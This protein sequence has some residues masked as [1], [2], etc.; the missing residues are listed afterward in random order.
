MEALENPVEWES[1]KE[2]LKSTAEEVIRQHRK[3]KRKPWMKEH[4]MDLIDR[5]N[6]MRKINNETYKII[7]AEIQRE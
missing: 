2:I 3:R 5:R 4:I 1:V 6:K 7:S